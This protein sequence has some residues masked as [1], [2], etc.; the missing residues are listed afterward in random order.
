M[1]IIFL[2]E[3]CCSG[4]KKGDICTPNRGERPEG[5]FET[6]RGIGVKKSPIKSTK[7]QNFKFILISC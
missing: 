2:G 5:V 7:E 3:E 6:G 1:E 4:R